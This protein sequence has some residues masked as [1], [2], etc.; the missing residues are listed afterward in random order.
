MGQVKQAFEQRVIAIP[1]ERI[2]PTRK[3]DKG[4][5]G[6]KKFST[7]LTSIRELGVIEPLA[8]HP[9]PV[10]TG[11]VSSYILGLAPAKPNTSTPLI[12]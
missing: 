5:H 2:L 9:Q 12:R 4:I 8:V 7:I 11:S 6:S 10:I 1:L 3:L